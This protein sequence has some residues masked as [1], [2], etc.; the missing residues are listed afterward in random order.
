MI[1]PGYFTHQKIFDP[2]LISVIMHFHMTTQLQIEII[3]YQF[4]VAGRN[5]RNYL[6]HEILKK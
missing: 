1:A 6:I 3:V 2:G 4:I 5:M